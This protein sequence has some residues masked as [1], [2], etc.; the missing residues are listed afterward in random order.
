MSNLKD[1]YF[2]LPENL[3]AQNPADKRDESRLMLIDRK[4]N[5]TVHKNF[6]NIIDYLNKGDVLVINES[7]VFPARL[8]GERINPLPA[9][10]GHG[11][12]PLQRIEFLLLENKGGD[13]WEIIMKPGRKGK[14]D[15]VFSF[16]NGKIK[17]KVLQSLDNGNKLVEFEYDKYNGGV[18]SRNAGVGVPYTGFFDILDEIGKIPLPPYIRE[19]EVKVNAKERYQTVYAKE[20]KK[21]SSA[22]PTAGLHFTSE[23]LNLLKAKGVIICPITL[24]VGLGTFRPV[25]TENISEHKM[26]EEYYNI[27]ESG[28]D[29]ITKAKLENRRVIA[30]GTTSCRTLEGNFAKYGKITACEDRTDIFIYGDYKFNITDALITNFHLPESTLLMLVSAFYT[31]ENILEAYK[32]AVEN[33]YRFFSFGDAMMIL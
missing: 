23:L 24:H 26:H 11:N 4:N 25:K 3:I 12:P 21:G 31:R 29:E 5:K 16:G 22:A 19:S 6:Y 20:D 28:A 10:G 18:N 8:I 30:V 2:D 27:S 7:K 32:T 15:A 13:I 9:A 33:K 1:Y 17:A 14:K